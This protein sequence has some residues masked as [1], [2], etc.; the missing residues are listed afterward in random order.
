MH[1]TMEKVQHKGHEDGAELL[2]EVENDASS[3]AYPCH[4]SRE[5]M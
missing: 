4:K 3:I 2:S 1:D 5:I